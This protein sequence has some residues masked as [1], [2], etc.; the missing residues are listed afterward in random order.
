[1]NQRAAT[2][3]VGLLTIVSLAVLITTVIWLRGRGLGGGISYEVSFRDVDGLRQGAPVQ[4][5]GIRVG[6]VDQVEPVVTDK[7]RYRVRVL[8][9]VTEE[10][11][12]V[13]KGS[14]VSLE[15]SGL[16][17]E[18]FIEITP[19][20]ARRF[21]ITTPVS[22]PVINTGTRIMVAFRDG[23]V[24]VGKVLHVNSEEDLSVTGKKIFHHRISY[25]IDRPGYLP[26]DQTQFQ[27]ISKDPNAGSP[28][29]VL[30]D[31][32]SVLEPAP[33]PEAYFTVENPLRLKEFLETQLASAE[34]LK[35]TNDKI[36]QL[37]SDETILTL[38]GTIKNSE[39]LTAQATSVLKQT[40][41]MLTATSQDIHSLVASTQ[42]LT[43]SV[44]AVSDNI[45]EIV[46]DPQLKANIQ[47]TVKS[48]DQSSE[49][50]SALL[51]DPKLD[52]ILNDAQLASK[53]SAELMQYLRA[54]AVDNDL[55]GRLNES[56]TSLNTSLSRL[57]GIMENLEG[58]TNDKD[59]IRDILE[60]T[61]ST[62]QNLNKFSERL[63]KRFLLFRLLF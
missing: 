59:A 43:T 53:N 14:L 46:G 60:E 48:I 57:S 55:Q 3:K 16:I 29:L 39:Q 41:S 42:H 62:S 4:M 15:Q 35:L 19:P 28:Y 54:T 22:D 32:E 38:Q 37:L 45:N 63:N 50:L 2:V 56:M 26:P 23:L 8:F 20:R 24:Q 51:N 1:M 6:F 61:R 11:V 36:N 21:E 49:A 27:V 31:P 9:T 34:S 12:K 17:G 33:P 25:T 52:V 7:K 47:R 44:V 13:P 58:V 5:M 30:L 10:G 18:K 40:N